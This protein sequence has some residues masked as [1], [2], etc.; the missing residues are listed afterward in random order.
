MA[1]QDSQRI[2]AGEPSSAVVQ[3]DDAIEM[4]PLGLVPTQE[5]FPQLPESEK[6]SEA[7]PTTWK[8]GP[9]QWAVLGCL[10]LLSFVVSLD[11]TI[12]IPALPVSILAPIQAPDY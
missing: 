4:V 10:A 1:T 2:T 7:P 6:S 3:Q 5:D 8:A 11:A 9:R 12:V